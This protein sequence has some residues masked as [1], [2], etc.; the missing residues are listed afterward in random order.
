MIQYFFNSLMGVL[1]LTALMILVVGSAWVLVV[2]INELCEALGVDLWKNFGASVLPKKRQR[3][4][5]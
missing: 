2:A 3:L 5:R 4:G 1:L